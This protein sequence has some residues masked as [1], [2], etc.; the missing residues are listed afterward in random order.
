MPKPPI[1]AN[2]SPVKV[3]ELADVASLLA[4]RRNTEP[5]LDEPP[6][7][8][9]RRVAGLCVNHVDALIDVWAPSLQSIESYAS[10]LV[11]EQELRD[12]GALVFEYMIR[13]IGG[14]PVRPELVAIPRKIGHKRALQGVPLDDIL[15]AIRSDYNVIWRAMLAFSRPDEH[16]D[17]LDSAVRVWAAVE[18]QIIEVSRA[19]RETALELARNRADEQQEWFSQLCG[20]HGHSRQVITSAARALGVAANGMFLVVAASGKDF[21]PLH[22]AAK[23]ANAAGRRAHVLKTVGGTVLLLQEARRRESFQGSLPAGALAY[24]DQVDGLGKV[25]RAVVIALASAAILPRDTHS[26]VGIDSCWPAVILAE[27]EAAAALLRDRINSKL[28]ATRRGDRQALLRTLK[29]Y[30]ASGSIPETAELEF[31]HRN[32]VLNRLTQVRDLTGLDPR[33]PLE[34]AVLILALESERLSG[35]SET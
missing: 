15:L 29:V 19:Y 7:T 20:S 24:V 5:R 32:T 26:P 8:A 17:L 4:I 16:P 35:L 10:H 9:V 1:A 14:L 22:V 21:S 30:F 12:D 3:E 31:C 33:V 18:H 34:A 27:A 13:L 25:P 28:L 11:S 23:A 2:Y 6:P